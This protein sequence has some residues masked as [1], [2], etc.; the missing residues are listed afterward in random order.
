MIPAS[1][2]KAV[3]RRCDVHSTAS[4]VLILDDAHISSAPK[5]QRFTCTHAPGARA[6]STGGAPSPTRSLSRLPAP[7]RGCPGAGPLESW[8]QSSGSPSV[9]SLPPARWVRR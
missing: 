6:K 8:F 2:A 9:S 7:P 3:G 5:E 4:W 1:D